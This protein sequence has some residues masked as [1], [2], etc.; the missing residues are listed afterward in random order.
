MDSP[1]PGHHARADGIELDVA[2]AG[3]Q[4]ALALDRRRPKA[5]LPERAGPPVGRVD[6]PDIADAEPL[7]HPRR[8]VGG[9]GGQQQVHV[10]GHQDIGV[11][12]ASVVPRRLRQKPAIARIVVV[13]EE[14]RLPIVA[15]LDH[16]HRLIRQKI[17][18]KPR[19]QPACLMRTWTILSPGAEYV[20]YDPI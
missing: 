18:P 15:A 2:I 12:G 16:V 8:A 17:P 14:D 4:V 5:S 13:M 11:H 6:M 19:H 9:A 3:Q 1:P 7:H 10:V 20:H